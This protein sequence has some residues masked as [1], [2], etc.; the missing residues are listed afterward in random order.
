MGNGWDT[1]SVGDMGVVGGRHPVG[2]T[3]VVGGKGDLGSAWVF[4]S[5][6]N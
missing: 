6:D 5:V 3:G 4:G 2:Q 1:K